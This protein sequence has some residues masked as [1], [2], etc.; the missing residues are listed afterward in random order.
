M[1]NNTVA[2]KEV[3]ETNNV[4]NTKNKSKETVDYKSKWE[5]VRENLLIQHKESID[6]IAVHTK[7]ASKIEG[8]IEVN[9][10]LFLEEENSES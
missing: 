8:T 4:M 1:S 2:T 7:R 9:D 6:L 5:E 3:K 10:Q